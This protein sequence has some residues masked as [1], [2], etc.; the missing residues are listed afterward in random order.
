MA[1]LRIRVEHIIQ[2]H[3]HIHTIHKHIHT[4]TCMYCAARLLTR[5]LPYGR[6]RAFV[7]RQLASQ[8]AAFLHSV[9]LHTIHYTCIYMYHYTETHMYSICICTCTRTCTYMRWARVRVYRIARVRRRNARLLV[10]SW[11]A[12]AQL[13]H[14]QAIF[15]H[16]RVINVW[17][18]TNADLSLWFALETSAAVFLQTH[19]A[20][21]YRR[22]SY[23]RNYKYSHINN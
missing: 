22:F 12:S 15:V 11:P 19:C 23:K 16:S 18:N 2:V 10:D 20:A 17:H 4:R 7:S 13:W 6:E 9:Y 8:H 21:I 3:L 1:W 14:T 5:A